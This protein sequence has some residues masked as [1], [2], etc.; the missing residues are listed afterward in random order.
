VS[1][2]EDAIETGIIYLIEGVGGFGLAPKVMEGALRGAGVPHELRH[3][4]WSHGFGRWHA[5]LTDAENFRRK[6]SKLADS[7][8]DFRT[9]NT[10]RPVFV[11][12]KSGGTAVALSATEQ[13]PADSIERVVLLSPAVSPVYH[14]RPALRAVRSDLTSFWSPRDK[15]ILGFGTSIFGTADGLIGDAA[16]RVGFRLPAG[17][18]ATSDADYRKLRQIE[19]DATMQRAYNYGTH[20][21]TS[22]PL[23]V[24]YYV[25]PLIG[26]RSDS[27][28]TPAAGAST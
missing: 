2:T 12:A 19:W 28:T 15:F 4:H 1:E 3:F 8:M 5:D 21:G 7:I 6:A 18:D 11:V 17:V 13:L 10:G 23:F 25:A 16:G 27:D 24:R 22:M 9:G 20:I 26:G 14:L